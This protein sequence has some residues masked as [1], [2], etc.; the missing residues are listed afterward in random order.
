MLSLI[1]IHLLWVKGEGRGLGTRVFLVSHVWVSLGTIV[2]TVIIA[3][4]VKLIIVLRLTLDSLSVLAAVL[5]LVNLYDLVIDLDLDMQNLGSRPL[6]V[7]T[8]LLA[9][10]LA[11]A[12]F[13]PRPLPVGFSSCF[14]AQVPPLLLELLEFILHL[15]L[16]LLA[17]HVVLVHLG[18]MLLASGLQLCLLLP[19]LPLLIHDG[20]L[21]VTQ[22]LCELSVLASSNK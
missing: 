5:R 17:E 20:P 16:V 9:L 4:V 12:S 11:P 13:G 22:H 18:Q 10:L 6:S 19:E 8:L 15:L 7:G 21:L 2:A 3:L 14:T 1:I